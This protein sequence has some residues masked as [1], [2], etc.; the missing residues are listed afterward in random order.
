MRW[1]GRRAI[2]L[3]AQ[4]KTCSSTRPQRRS[5]RIRS[6]RKRLGADQRGFVRAVATAQREPISATVVRALLSGAE[7]Y[8]PTAKQRP[9]HRR[10]IRLL[11]ELNDGFTSGTN[12]RPETRVIRSVVADL[13]RL[14][15]ILLLIDEFGKNLEAFADSRSDA[16]LFLLQE[17]AEWTRGGDGLPLAL[18]TMQHLAFDE[19]A[20]TASASQRREW[21]K[22]QGRFEDIPFVDSPLQTRAL[23]AAA[24]GTAREPLATALAGWADSQQKALGATGLIDLAAAPG[25]LA[26]CWPLHPLSLAVLPDLCERYGQNER[27]LFSFLAGP[28]PRAVPA[29]LSAHEWRA[30]AEL[31]S[32]R[33]PQLYDYFIESASTMVGVSSAAS[34]WLEIDTRIRDSHGLRPGQLRVL[35]AIG[36]LNLVSAGGSLRASRDVIVYACVDGQAETATPDEVATR[37]AELDELGLVTYRDFAD[38]FRVWQGSDMDLRS[39]LEVARRRVRDLGPADLLDRV[40][41]LGP[42]V[43][44]RHSHRTG[45]LRAFARG[46]VEPTADSIDPLG[47]EDRPDGSAFYVLGPEAPTK[48]VTNRTDR[49]PIAFLTTADPAPL[50]A[51]AVEL[52]AID[53]LLSDNDDLG[54]DWVA[55]RELIERRVEARSTLEHEFEHAFGALSDARGNWLYQKPGK[56]RT[57]WRTAETISASQALSQ[58]ADVWYDQAPEIHNDLANRHH[59]SSQAAKARRVLVEAMVASPTSES[60]GIA[61][62]GPDHTMYLTLLRETELHRFDGD[63]WRFLE[64][65]SASPVADVWS[66]LVALLRE[67]VDGRTRVDDIFGLLSQPPYGVREG[68]APVLLVAALIINAGRGRPLRARNIPAC[69]FRRRDRAAVAQPGQL[70]DQA[71]RKPERFPGRLPDRRRSRAWDSGECRSEKS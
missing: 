33:L 39:A 27:T 44:A 14:A 20:D 37:L 12:T 28:E 55:R 53:E 49:K 16:D 66:H 11:N 58:V 48:A 15:P 38:E 65:S 59:L 71:F 43:A 32:V 23:I 9:A 13:G 30:K 52:A 60:L 40:L 54:D 5:R 6:A 70:R 22:I 41:P 51:A 63:E 18:V 29:F 24:F 64:P 21:A 8:E 25:V 2:P 19:Y 1:S 50:V 68:I 56:T 26:A 7:R 10:V 34:R 45:T 62:N 35:K 67:A 57:T 69:S 46:W 47:T 17:L 42:I 31:P 3:E 61:G 36:L 4:L